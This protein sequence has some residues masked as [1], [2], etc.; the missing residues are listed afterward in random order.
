MSMLSIHSKGLSLRVRLSSYHCI[1]ICVENEGDS[2]IS[3]TNTQQSSNS[4]QVQQ[5]DEVKPVS[6]AAKLST[7]FVAEVISSVLP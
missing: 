6:E 7:E 3:A 2:A 1:A 5:K 4:V